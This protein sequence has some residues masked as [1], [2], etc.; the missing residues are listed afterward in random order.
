MQLLV[1]KIESKEVV[2]LQKTNKYLILEPFFMRVINEMV[3]GLN[4]SDLLDFCIHKSSFSI[5]KSKLIV[6]A[7]WNIKQDN[8]LETLQQQYQQ[9]ISA[10]E[11]PT[12]LEYISYTYNYNSKHLR[13]RYSNVALAERI[14]PKFKHLCNDF[15]SSVFSGLICVSEFRGFFY[16]RVNNTIIGKWLEHDFHFLLGKFAMGLL[17]LYNNKTD[18]DW[19]AV[20]HAS[21]VCK[22]ENALVFLGESGSGKSTATALLSLNGFTLLADDFVPI[23]SKSSKVASF[24][25]A[26]SVKESLLYEF[27]AYFPELKKSTLLTKD[28]QTKFKYLYPNSTKTQESKFVNTKALVFI[29]YT[30]NGDNKLLKI[31]QLTALQKLIPDSWISPER[32]N[33][34][35]FLDWMAKVPCYELHYSD[36]KY[37]IDISEKLMN[38]EH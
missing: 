34:S 19:L 37:L 5:N 35:L 22:D 25:A 18:I 8:E 20:L 15:S 6:D 26:V 9:L 32:E 21:A 31:G 27:D 7:C 16:L 11:L 2:W 3:K 17:N 13:V 36:N 29:K 23:D 12:E 30:K 10:E 38:N 24:P 33:V 1:N 4:K 14:H 28:K